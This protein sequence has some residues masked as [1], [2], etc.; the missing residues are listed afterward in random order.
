[1]PVMNKPRI[2]VLIT[3]GLPDGILGIPDLGLP[4]FYR[5]AWKRKIQRSTDIPE[6][7]KQAIIESMISDGVRLLKLDPDGP[8]IQ[9]GPETGWTWIRQA[10]DRKLYVWRTANPDVGEPDF[11]DEID[12]K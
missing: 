1:M 2:L 7:A 6:D 3:S 5:T 10:A 12:D 4:D 11:P 9:A 8:E